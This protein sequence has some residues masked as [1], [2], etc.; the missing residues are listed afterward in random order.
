MDD[1]TDSRPYSWKIGTVK[2]HHS[3]PNIHPTVFHKGF[4][5]G[6]WC[7]AAGMYA[8]TIQ[9]ITIWVYC[10]YPVSDYTVLYNGYFRALSVF[11]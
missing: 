4:F 3:Q 6:K 5:V 10:S 11:L 1:W 2:F 9:K 7:P 8:D